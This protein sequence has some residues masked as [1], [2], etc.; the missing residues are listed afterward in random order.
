MKPYFESEYLT[1]YNC[2]CMELMATMNAKEYELAICDPPYG[3]GCLDKPTDK[4]SRKNRIFNTKHR[5]NCGAGKLKNRTL[6]KSQISWDD[7]TP[8]DEYFDTL[9]EVSKNQIIWG[10]NY[11]PLSPTRCVIAWDKVQPWENFSQWEMAWTSFD[12]PARLYQFDNRTGDKIHPTQKPV[13]LYAWLLKNYAN[14][15]D[16]ILDTH[17]GS[18]SIAI[19]CHYA[20]HHLTAC[21]LDSDYCQMAVERYKRETAQMTLF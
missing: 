19:A 2:D 6:N 14:E 7:E 20:K 5:L 18:G 8:K 15:G 11:F 13:K 3:I 9:F 10:G 4:E 12:S 16:R 21:E 1:L 17:F